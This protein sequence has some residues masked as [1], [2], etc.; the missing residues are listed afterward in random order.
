MSGKTNCAD[1]TTA[2]LAGVAELNFL[3]F[4]LSTL[5][6]SNLKSGDFAGLTGLTDLNLD[7]NQL[8]TLPADIFSGLSALTTLTLNNNQLSTLPTGIFAGLTAL[9][10]LDL[11]GNSLPT[12]LPASLF[13]DVPRNAI[14][15]PTGTTINDIPT[16]VGTIA[17]IT[18]LVESGNPQ[19]VDVA[20][21][22]SDPNDT[23]TY[24]V[25]SNNTATVAVAVSGSTITITPVAIGTADIT[26]TA[27]DTAG[28]TATQTFTVNITSTA[29][30]DLC[31]RTAVVKNEIVASVS[32]KTNCADIT[33]AELAGVAELNF[34]GFSLST[35]RGS[36]LK[37]GDFA[38]L[39]GLTDLNLDG[40]QLT[41]LPADIFSGLSA[42]TTLT[43]NNNQLSTLPT[44]IFA[45]LTALTDL[46]LSSNSLPTSLPASLFAD[47]PRNAIT[48]P[49]GTTINDIPTTVGTI[50]NIT[51]LVESGNPQTVDVADKFSDPNDTLTYTVESNNTATVAVAV[52]GSTIT[53]TPVA[54]GTADITVTATDTA[55]QTATQTFTVNITSTAPT[56]LCSRTTA[57]KNEIVASVSGKTNCADITTAELAGVAEL[58]FLGFSLSTLR[59]SNLKSGDF[60]GLTGLTDLNLD[61]NQLTTLPADIFSGLSALTTLTLNNNQLSTLP[62]GVFSGLTS[63]TTLNLSGNSLPTSLPAS[64][65]ADVPRN[66]I[67]LPTGTTINDIPTTV[68]TI[69]N[70]TDLV[71]SGN[72]QTV[73]VADK[74]S[75]PNDT[76]TYTV[77][78]NNT[79]TVAVA[80]SGSTITITPVAIGTADITVTATDTAGQTATQTFTVN[81]TSTAPTDLCSRTTAVKNEIV[82]SVSGK[83][84]CADITTAELA[85][86]AELNFLGFS[87]STLRG[88][89]LKSG[90][91]AGLT[92]LTDLN[93]DGNQLT[94]LPADIFSGLSAL[95]TLT[96]NNNQ[97]S[98]LPTG[99]FAGLTA[100]T[101]LD[102]SSN[103]LPT[104]LPASLFADVPRNAITLPTGTTVDYIPT[105]VGS[106]A[107]IDLVENGSPQT[108]DV[109][110]KF[111]DTG[112]TLTY[113]V[114]SNNTATATVAVSGSTV[115]ITPV[116]IGTATITITAADT[117]GQT[118]TQTLMVSVNAQGAD[119]TDLCSR[120]EAVKNVI[121]SEVSGKTN[122]ADITTAELAGVTRIL[123]ATASSNTPQLS[124]AGS[125][126]KSG[127]FAGLT[128]L[129][130]LDLDF[131]EITTLPADIF[132]GLSA[133]TSLRLNNN[134]LSTLPSGI[135]SGLTSLTD[136]RLSNNP[137]PASLPAS[138]FADVSRNAITLPTGTTINAAAPTTV[139][140]IA[141]ITNLVANG[142]PQ[143]VDVANK[144][145]DTG[146][147]LTYTVESNNTATATVT[148]AVSGS[149]T[150]TITPVAIGTATITITATDTAGQTVTQTFTVNITS[151]A[152][153]DLCSR[154]TAVKNE[155][156]ASVSGKTNCAD[157]T[158]AEL[159]GVAELNFLGFSLST[160]RGS[161]LKSGDF[162]GLTGL[163]DLNLDGNQLTT[164]P[165]DIFSGLSALTTL[166]LNNNQLSTLP[167]GIFAGLTALTD[168]DLSSNSLPTSLPASLFA[169]VPQNAITLPTG[170][171][172]NDIPTT[173]GTIANITD[174]VEN[175]SPQTVDVANK[176]SDTGDTLT[177]TVES[178][179]TATVTVAV[180]G[181]TITITPVAIGTAD[182]TI[183][184]TDTAGQTAT[185]TF[186]VTVVD[187]TPVA[188]PSISISPATVTAT[189]G[190]AIANI[191]IDSSG[192]AVDSY[193]ISPTLTAG[194][195]L[196][197]ATATISGTPTATA[198]SRTYTITASNSAGTDTAMVNITV[199][200]APVVNNP[201]PTIADVLGNIDL[202]VN[203]QSHTLN[204]ANKFSDPDDTL[205][206]SVQS[207]NTATASVDVSGN[208]VTITPIAIGTTTITVTAADTIGQT[209]TQTF[210]VTVISS[211]L[212]NPTVC[213]RHPKVQ[214]V[215]IQNVHG[216][217]AC[218]D[219]T[220]ADLAGINSL[221]HTGGFDFVPPKRSD[222]AGLT[223][224]LNLDISGNNNF[225]GL[226]TLPA[227]LFQDLPALRNLSL[228]NNQL[229]TLPIGIFEGL[230]LIG[231]TLGGNPWVSLPTNIFNEMASV[232]QTTRMSVMSLASV[233]AA[234]PAANGTIPAQSLARTADPLTLEVATFFSDPGDTLTYTA[235]SATPAIASVAIT[236][237][238]LT[239]TPVALG[240]TNIMVT[241]RDTAGQPVT[242]TFALTVSG[243]AAAVA[244]PDISPSVPAL[245]A[246][247]AVAI[248]PI[249]IDAAAGGAVDSYSI[250]PDLPAGLS[251]D[252]SSGEISGTPTVV[253]G[254]QI[255]TITATNTTG[256]DTAS[257]T[258]TVNTVA[259]RISIS[260]ATL[261]ANMGSPI[262]PITITPIGGGAV[263]SYGIAPDIQNGLLFD[264]TDG[265][266]SGTPTAVAEAIT[267][268]ITA[269]NSGGD[270]TAMVT[271][272]VEAPDTTPPSV[273]I[274]SLPESA[275]IVDGDTVN[276]TTLRY[277]VAFSELISGFEIDDI[278]V[279]GTAAVAASGLT[280]G[281]NG[282]GLF[283]RFEV[284]KGNLDGTVI[285]SIA[286][287]IAED[288]A[289]NGNTASGDY[290][291]T[292][293]TTPPVITLTGEAAL[294]LVRGTDYNDAGAT[295]N[296]NIGGDI[297]GSITTSFTLDGTAATTL[298]SSLPG[299]Y[300][301]TYNVS[302]AANNPAMAVTR[303][304]T[305]VEALS[306][307]T[308]GV[309]ATA[310]GD[311]IRLQFFDQQLT[312][313]GAAPGDFTLSG[314][315]AA[316]I[317]VTA[318]AVDAEDSTVL[319]LTLSGNI[320]K[321]AA[322][323]LAYTRTAG[324]ISGVFST[325]SISSNGIV[326]DFAATDVD[327]SN[328]VAPDQTE[329]TIQIASTATSPTNANPIPINLTFSESLTGFEESNITV[330]G[331]TITAG[332]YLVTSSNPDGSSLGASFTITPS[333]DGLITVRIAA[334]A[335]Q[336]L[337]TN[338][339]PAASFD[340]T[341][342]GTAPVVTIST[343]AQAVNDAAFT[344]TGTVE[345]GATVDVLK[346]G[347]SIGAA[348]VTDTT[349]TLAVTLTDGANLFTVTASDTAGNVS[350]ASA[351]VSITLNTTTAP[352]IS[353]TPATVTA[354]AGTAITPITITSS[355][356]DVDSYSIEP[357][358]GN[359]L[360]FSTSTGIISGTPDAVADAIPYTITATNSGGMATATVTIT[361]NAAVLAP[362]IP[363]SATPFGVNLTVGV[364]ISPI[365]IVNS[366][367]AATYSFSPDLPAGLSI[368]STTGTISGTPTAATTG[369]AISYTI[370]ATNSAGSDSIQG[371]L[372]VQQGVAAP[373]ISVSP[374]MLT[375]TVGIAV[376]T[377]PITIT[378][379]GGHV[380]SYTIEDANGQTLSENTGLSH[381]ADGVIFGT[382]TMSAS[383]E[384]YTITAT[385]RNG[386]SDSATI[387]ITVNEAVPSISID[388][389]T[390]VATVDSAIV[391]I[392]I[393][394]TGGT[395]ASYSIMPAITNGLSF[396]TTTGTISGTPDAVAPEIIYTITATNSGGT[397]TATVAITVNA[398]AV[399][400]PIISISATT[401]TATVG[402]A[403]ADITIDS[404][405]GGGG[406]VASYGIDPNL[407]AGLLFDANTGTISGTPTAVAEAISY[408]ITA[409]NSGGTATVTLTIVITNINE[410]P[411]I[412]S[413]NG[414]E[415]YE[416][417]L[418]ENIQTVATIIAT[419][420]DANTTLFYS[421]V[422]RYDSPLYE[423]T[424][425]GVL[426][427]KSAYI[428]D[429][430]MPRG[431]R[432]NINL[433]KTRGYWVTVTVS[434][435]SLTD[436]ILIK[437][438]IQDVNEAPTLADTTLQISE[439]S[440]NGA[441]VGDITGQD[442][443]TAAPNNSL[444]YSITG[445]NTNDAFV[446]SNTGAIT[447]NGDGKIDFETTAIYTL[448]VTVADGGSPALTGT[449]T[450]TINV[451]D[452]NEAPTIASTI[453]NIT[454]LVA[455]G[456]PQTVDVADKFNDTDALTFSATSNNPSIASVSGSTTITITPVAAGSA[457]I[458]VTATD[459]ANQTVTQT[460]V[461]SVSNPIATNPAPTTVG[462]IAD[463]TNLVANGN[464]QTVDVASNFNDTDALTFSATSNNPNIASVSG[465]T[466]I[467]I[468]PLAVG[469]TTITVTATDT[470]NQTV[471]Q[472]FVVSVSNPAV[473]PNP[474]PTTVGTIADITNLVANGNPQTVDVASNFNDTDAL[475][476]SATSNN[477]NIA[478]V[479]GST[480]ITI[481]PLAVGTTTITVTATDT[482]N[483]TV[484]QTFVVSVSNPAVVP[485]LAPTT[486]GTIA[487]ITNLVANGN[488]QTVDVASNFN[489]TDALTFS[490]TSNNP[491]IASVSGSTTITITPLAVGTTT[492]T[493]TATDTANQTVTQTFVVSVSNPAVVPNPAPTTVGTIADITNLVANGNPQTVDV[494]SNFND[495]DALTFSAM[496]NNPSIASVS[497]ST[498]ITITPLAAGT[499]TITVTAT[500]TANQTVTQTFVVSV[501]N[502]AVVPNP[503]PTTVGTIADITNLV[504]NGNTQ[505]VDVASKFN[506]TDALTFS[507]TSNNPSIASV[508]GSTTI[509][510]TPLAVG[511][512]TI[513]VTATDTANQTVTQTFVVS[514]SNPAVVP[515]P[516]PTTVG[517]IADITNLVANDNPQTVDVASNFND[518]DALIFSATSN[519]PNIASVSGSTTITI[520]PL[521][522]GTTTITVTATDTANQTVTQ[523]FVV[524]VSNPAVVPNP[525]PTT[526]GTIADITNLVANGNPQ[527][528]DVAGKFN[529]TDALT[530]SATSN[531]PNIASVSGSTTI[532]I[533]P[534]AV[535]TTTITVTATDTANQTVTQTFVVSVSN[536]APIT[537]PTAKATESVTVS[538]KTIE[539]GG[540]SITVESRT[541]QVEVTTGVGEA[542]TITGFSAAEVPDEKL[543]TIANKA[544]ATG[545][546]DFTKA[547]PSIDST[548]TPT[549]VVN[550][551]VDITVNEG[552]CP[553]KGCEVTLSYEAGDV[554]AGKDPY[555]FHYDETKGKWEALPHVRHD[556]I[557]RKV[558]ALATSFSPFALFN[559]SRADKLA[560]QLNK[561]ILPNLVQT[562]LAST[563]AAVSNRMDAAFSGRPQ[564]AS[565]QFDGQTVQLDSQTRLSTNLHNT[566]EQKL[567][568]YIKALKDDTLDWKRL[569][570]NSSFVM[571]LNALDEDGGAGATVWGSGE[572]INLS[573]KDWKGNVFN[574]Q[575]GV[576]QRIKDDLLAGGLVSWSKGDV[577]YTLGR[578]RGKYTHRVTSIHPYMARSRDGVNLWG[579]V[580]YGQGELSIKAQGDNQN[581]R[582]SDTR[583]LSL[584][585]GVSG[586][587]TQYGQSGLKL[588][589]DMTLAQI[590][591]DGSTD[592]PADK[593]SSQRLRLLLEIEKERP[594]ASGGRFNPVVEIGL[595]YDG[596]TGESGIGA[597]LGLG[598]RYAN[599]TGLMVEGK[600]HT[601]V[602]RKDYKEWGVQ[603]VIRQQSGANDQGLTFSL[604][605]SYGATGNS[606]NQAW[607]QELADGNNR[608][609]DYR[610]RLDVNMGYGLFTGG[611]LLTPY[612]ELRM[613]DS[614]RYRLGLRWKPNSPFNLHLYGER[615]TSN[616]SDRVLLESHIR[617]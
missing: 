135:F 279:S 493:V 10:D 223:T 201:A 478:S 147:T 104:S 221:V 399:A 168:L 579:S 581:E 361:V 533:T 280:G 298:N 11:S 422:D 71:E 567:P 354:T 596:G 558:T 18:D 158:T 510:I 278:T 439:N 34:L 215:I 475:T 229:R 495:T 254:E 46:D 443:D 37:S 379:N 41:T 565:Y 553:S 240:T 251:I 103:S 39:T 86:V 29:P 605:P 150:I 119:P 524:S 375:F 318:L 230:S 44:G 383:T 258:I 8:T 465:S 195:T 219:I 386:V 255:Y 301:I 384:I 137:L 390:L 300:I 347:T 516:A 78:S 15:L 304:V 360:L 87:L 6:G 228:T 267:Y 246:T 432:G 461:V 358:I 32:G 428:P 30:T 132:S 487:D 106:F 199:N 248:T 377:D 225:G 277:E 68:G 395:V 166:T 202:A 374:S 276:A 601:L 372:T 356:G 462:T 472:T 525:A 551:A 496:S 464:P 47:V 530:F 509:T 378:N 17:N 526:V 450:I 170:T 371:L 217:S 142:N 96:L 61:G 7:G 321:D 339:N 542:T 156:V 25:E 423:I 444:T 314:A 290:T 334:G 273:T 93:L 537:T 115:T 425:D 200:A 363:P 241:A 528:V 141:N 320:A 161:N 376:T 259:P 608:N 457:T 329:P 125:N 189:V 90:D 203:A 214:E 174:L 414:V 76:L 505:T 167:T 79:A 151:T 293:D 490:A 521:A 346:D 244:A 545:G 340:I 614:N 149:T 449:A 578:E 341:Y 546:I 401:V 417:N 426:K 194:L 70:I 431:R 130:R 476:F 447:V 573:D 370:T 264:T 285:V 283:F 474:A 42:L 617:F 307:N 595:R 165:A 332:S 133:L 40:N 77:E 89:N 310:A 65:F 403:I 206:F 515:N 50:A 24:T 548:I 275:N 210:M 404:T 494:A 506:D 328:I 514:V 145:S 297:T 468:T 392:T 160:L 520:T 274:S 590:D 51:D 473:V 367:G 571:P 412:T 523:T 64:L 192:G 331:G 599:S 127:D 577:D 190:T 471:T 154:T 345:A 129:T 467:T 146:D 564:A 281:A 451:N 556:T 585:A 294:T 402:T 563:M 286:E 101:D 209:V 2:E 606:A 84:N 587:L 224:L 382:P 26:I 5:R 289:G 48:L 398:A 540:S 369:G 31:S 409:T 257:V 282:T 181:S 308:N 502:P 446:I 54:I 335:A 207:D 569:I 317:T 602:G 479:S 480:T 22:F 213:M 85:G 19:T 470:A 430:E 427:F 204:V 109:A 477:P 69:A 501:S 271:I 92:G 4:S 323:T 438:T 380:N 58:N 336:N 415:V 407:P 441:S 38:G 231:L 107:D 3:G 498:T 75:D 197:T 456:N 406:A 97:L 247:Q 52:S 169:D 185:Q 333:N 9:T 326:I 353:I 488:P 263:V 609:D 236:G 613:G 27:A 139:G 364:P 222:F 20:D 13:A 554:P 357:V 572:Y 435:G 102:L 338:G 342:D 108:V 591:I 453:A 485:N 440:I 94:T 178:N 497:G 193:S 171:T 144:F 547:P 164:L 172:I 232:S 327:T 489:D 249:T 580:G 610:A 481:T 448:T 562:M 436:E 583:L 295:A 62:T 136:L 397:A 262:M 122:C 588:K 205:T 155:I 418:N 459:T 59:G 306:P 117:A 111:S 159:A 500:D 188:V 460:F 550:T 373:D 220:A 303:M 143:T 299:T 126:L 615:K 14:T 80:V 138:L 309:I 366:G 513:T 311:K 555:V 157:I 337:A 120:T 72:P 243:D 33:T 362:D 110:N 305:T 607:E 603:G 134:Q 518:T 594:L 504:A 536:A 454:D 269:T 266:I 284:L 611:G 296:D 176:F 322:V 288:T 124:V 463:I 177:Y 389:A 469:T 88:S 413:Q 544:I 226:T 612:S 116:A 424:N 566:V 182:I 541:I 455:N 105:T 511:T 391:P 12:S 53:I 35:L 484:T 429:Y 549:L 216:K 270:G 598:G 532:T 234:L 575:L 21:K 452:V 196:D 348:N 381:S 239:I 313:N 394:S 208:M 503:A 67:T 486:V 519:N 91:F 36:N 218:G 131:N 153:T 538:E 557:N 387:T 408:I 458:T 352:S 212:P 250:M 316:G 419:D 312:N 393:A 527:T 261:V 349:W 437:V 574:V 576:D 140:T 16:T 365:T 343:Q 45:G 539:V 411:V 227:D 586:R 56:D 272:T 344:L 183:T 60:A 114:E 235:T 233:N 253:A 237:S 330:S 184:A 385:N 173:V 163:T 118:A 491:S 531:N 112:D 324:S 604:S 55:G 421:L 100:L 245:I 1:I 95:T 198:P 66:A 162:A 560:K 482:A 175:G 512:T 517:T 433:G 211:P 445:G 529:D 74:F 291:L 148:V 180:S 28:Q 82:A 81:I 350:E 410:A 593:L 420:V 570:G 508:S 534:L 57:V 256:D 552:A 405:T 559:A 238:T 113:T 83:T 507:A 268:T 252:P 302:D 535:G 191:T 123:F 63:L 152:P 186:V 23:L 292:I 597:V 388:P 99:I 600:F 616:D 492:I 43:L 49:T 416:L 121:V 582:S 584:A 287:N 522:V 98:T 499:T 543:E 466:T 434:D 325:D 315:A 355:G 396:N 260:P 128:G 319:I 368:D 187:T 483:Q 242:Q 561:D 568:T 589:S 179:N 442:P 359:G 73:D 265:A 400:V 592:I 351:A